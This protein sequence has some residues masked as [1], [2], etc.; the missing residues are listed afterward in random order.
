MLQ[1]AALLGGIPQAAGIRTAQ[2]QKRLDYI[3][4]AIKNPRGD[5]GSYDFLEPVFTVL[6]LTMDTKVKINR[7]KLFTT[8]AGREVYS[9]SAK[10]DDPI[11]GLT[12]NG[13]G[14]LHGKHLSACLTA[15]QEAMIV[16]HIARSFYYIFRGNSDQPQTLVTPQS[17]T[18]QNGGTSSYKQADV[19]YFRSIFHTIKKKREEE[20]TEDDESLRFCYFNFPDEHAAMLAEAQKNPKED[21]PAAGENGGTGGGT[22]AA[23]EDEDDNSLGEEISFG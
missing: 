4:K 7:L 3:E 13:K 12:S 8:R 15:A 17:L 22:G 14:M 21:P 18:P 11:T 16:L 20:L 2:Q 19:D 10:R 23:S 1:G 9:T 5:D 6:A